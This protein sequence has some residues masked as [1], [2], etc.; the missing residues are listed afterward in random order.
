MV[1][2]IK[3]H[4]FC[5][6]KFESV[7]DVFAE[8]FKSGLDVGAS[9]ALT[10]NGKF[11]IDIWA[12]H[13]DKA[14]TQPWEENT[15]VNV[16]STTKV[17]AALCVLI[18][19]DRGKI[20]LDA[21]VANY[22]PEFAQAGKEKLPV[23]YLM[24]HTAGLPGFDT[25]IKVEDLYN[26]EYCVNLLAAQKPWWEPGTESAY[27][28]ISF[29]YLL[30]ELV[31]RVSGK[32]IGTFF[33][34]EVANPLKADFHIGFSEDL[35]S[36]IAELIPPDVPEPES[37]VDIDP[38]SMLVRI[39]SNPSGIEIENALSREWRAAEI[40]SS[41]GHGNARSIVRITSA[42]ACGGELDGVKLLSLK[43]IEKAI[44]EQLYSKDLFFNSPTRWGL[45][46]SLVSKD[47]PISPN[48]R[49]FS[50]GGF[51]GSHVTVDLDAKMSWGFA[52]NNMVISLTGDPR[53]MK[54]RKAIWD[55]F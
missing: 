51:G 31:R 12:G 22:W 41:N 17:M 6:E 29:G 18:L 53:T 24:S 45:G 5:D 33:R 27:H 35:D 13:R 21:P 44:E 3:V 49:A 34:E 8:N 46:W 9:L 38:N 11:M 37:P 47:N 52:M 7:K 43:T 30:G 4:G 50:W 39:V 48:P 32:S 40:P 20:D 26:W 1:S 2:N 25:S 16:Y 15:I 19:V 36:R 54:L 42:L 55:A 14:Q 10:I 28:M 23:R